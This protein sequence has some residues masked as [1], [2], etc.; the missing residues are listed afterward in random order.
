MLIII[1]TESNC[2]RSLILADENIVNSFIKIMAN[3]VTFYKHML[4]SNCIFRKKIDH[5]LLIEHYDE[6]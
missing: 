4:F 3:F 2:F 1:N 6:G 5:Q